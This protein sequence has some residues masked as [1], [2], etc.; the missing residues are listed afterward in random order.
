MLTQ[1]VNDKTGEKEYCLVSTKDPSKILKWFGKEKPSDEAVSKEEARVEMFKHIP[2]KSLD[3]IFVEIGNIMLEIG[4]NLD[5]LE[6]GGPGSGSWED[7]GDPRFEHQGSG[8][9]KDTTKDSP[10]GKDS[11]GFHVAVPGDRIKTGLDNKSRYVVGEH[12]DY[13]LVQ[14][15]PPT[16][17][18]FENPNL[19]GA[20]HKSDVVSV[21]KT[22]RSIK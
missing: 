19:T 18:D 7:P 11:S 16:E 22:S 21:S 6:K 17:R 12:K 13:Y 9:E 10:R 3:E 4:D 2:K 20:V 8:K 15:K 1:R 5:V 14:E